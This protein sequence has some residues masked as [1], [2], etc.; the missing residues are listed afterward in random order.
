[1]SASVANEDRAAVGRRIG[2]AR[3]ERGFTQADLATRIGVSLGLVDR[4]ESGRT[5]PSDKLAQIAEVT[6]R[7]ISW[8]TER[9]DGE[10]AG[11]ESMLPAALGRRIAESRVQGGVTRREPPDERQAAAHDESGSQPPTAHRAPPVDPPRVA[12]ADTEPDRPAALARRWVELQVEL[13][14]ERRRHREAA[15]KG[16]RL[17]QE[18]SSVDAS[19][20]A[21]A[22][23]LQLSRS[24]LAVARTQEAR[25]GERVSQL[26]TQLRAAVTRADEVTGRV[27]R[28]ETEL[29]RSRERERSMAEEIEL[30]DADL[31]VR[32]AELDRRVKEL[33]HSRGS[34]ADRRSPGDVELRAAVVERP[35]ETA[36]PPQL[37]RPKETAGPP[38]L[39]PSKETA[40]PPQLERPKET[41]GPPQ[42]EPSKETAGPPQG[43]LGHR[44]TLLTALE[45]RLEKRRSG[46]PKS[47][48]HGAE[49][50]RNRPSDEHLAIVRDRGYRLVRR[51]GPAP[52]PGEILELDHDRYR[53]VRISASPFPEDDR[54]CAVLEPVIARPEQ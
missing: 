14:E 13:E 37:E 31:S 32:W 48:V 8:F 45:R 25:L 10:R 44:A 52:E 49:D 53:C 7:Q 21:L 20:R 9:H 35:K 42:L 4:Y 27:V 43:S 36:G 30:R 2:Q 54:S 46:K 29:Q 47:A 51:H 5:D 33:A 12:E 11:F 3:R 38:Q 1:M 28:A 15:A 19:Q 6:G 18:L 16:A 41:A 39:E 23:A 40:G 22:D 50:R 24:E 17:E 26:E 34:V